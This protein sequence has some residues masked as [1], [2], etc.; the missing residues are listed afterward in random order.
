MNRT[1]LN[2]WYMFFVQESIKYCIYYTPGCGD[3]YNYSE[4]FWWDC[5]E[6][7]ALYNLQKT[8]VCVCVTSQDQTHTHTNR[9]NTHTI[10]LRQVKTFPWV[11]A[12]QL[13]LCV[14]K[15]KD[16]SHTCTTSGLPF[17]SSIA[18]SL[19]YPWYRTGCWLAVRTALNK[20]H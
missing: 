1:D 8:C 16:A 10:N 20:S 17:K 2:V 3:L 9:G 6:G 15:L 18:T 14:N 19:H 5:A 13:L 4:Y 11:S 12:H 7:T